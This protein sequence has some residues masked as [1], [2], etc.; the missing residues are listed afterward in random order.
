MIEQRGPK[1]A[2]RYA[3]EVERRGAKVQLAIDSRT[4][5][6]GDSIDKTD[7]PDGQQTSTAAESS[8]KS[9]ESKSGKDKVEQEVI[10]LRGGFTRW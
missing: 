4:A 2:R 1:A 5:T 10:I 3:E 9:A 6:P 7:K 8:V